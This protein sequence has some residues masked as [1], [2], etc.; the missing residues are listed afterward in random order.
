MNADKDWR[1]MFACSS[2]GHMRWL[3]LQ[4]I[5]NQLPNNTKA[6]ISMSHNTESNVS[7]GQTGHYD[8]RD[9]GRICTSDEPK[10]IKSSQ[11][12]ELLDEGGALLDEL[13]EEINRSHRQFDMVLLPSYPHK[14]ETREDNQVQPVRSELAGKLN[15]RNSILR[16]MIGDLRALNNRS[17]VAP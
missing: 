12:D 17:T 14:C 4:E 7:C 11:I 13:S 2:G 16:A 9:A 8:P 3:C 15:T 6:E 1:T 5:Y 10:S